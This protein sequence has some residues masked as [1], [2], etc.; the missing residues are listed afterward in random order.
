MQS[1]GAVRFEKALAEAMLQGVGQWL[2]QAGREAH[3]LARAWGAQRNA[4]GLARGG[5]VMWRPMAARIR[6][7]A[8]VVVATDTGE[9]RVTDQDSG[10]FR[11]VQAHWAPACKASWEAAAGH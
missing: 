11:A 8:M 9:R 5:V 7:S 4:S 2:A 1:V 10:L 6:S 3:N